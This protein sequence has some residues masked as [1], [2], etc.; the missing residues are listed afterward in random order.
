MH[1]Q[2]KSMQQVRSHMQNRLVELFVDVQNIFF[3]F[4]FFFFSHTTKGILEFIDDGRSVLLVGGS[5]K[6]ASEIASHSA[7]AFDSAR[8]VT[9]HAHALAD[10]D[11]HTT[12]LSDGS[13]A[14]ANGRTVF[15]ADGKA[16][17][18]FYKGVAVTSDSALVIPLVRAHSS[19]Y[20][21]AKDGSLS[22]DSLLAGFDVSLVAALHARNGARVTAVGSLDLFADDLTERSPAGAA[23]ARASLVRLTAW[24]FGR[25]GVLRARD[26]EHKA[27][28]ARVG[29]GGQ[30]RI[31]QQIEFRVTIE[32]W[33][34]DKKRWAPYVAEDVQLEFTM[35]DPHVR[36]FLKSS[37]N[38]VYS[39]EFKLPDVYGVFTFRIT[40]NRPGYT[41]LLVETRTPVRPLRHDEYER[42]IVSAYP[43]YASAFSMMAGLFVF[44]IAFLYHGDDKQKTQ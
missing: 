1:W 23:A 7:F 33:D 35:L 43:Y 14:P 13:F 10:D 24:T 16:V 20:A 39:L 19:A 11:A 6:V 17:P 42:F 26:V 44:A 30:Y 37:S 9:D 3:F 32:E 41:P 28:G 12:V 31:G 18:L 36:Q 22:T 15:G 34:G 2:D 29:A 8:L 5:G 4:F 38:G 21:A 40:Y 25:H 27:I